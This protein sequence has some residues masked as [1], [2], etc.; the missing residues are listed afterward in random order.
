MKNRLMFFNIK[1]IYI[2]EKKI[3]L[4]QKGPLDS[5]RQRKGVHCHIFFYKRRNSLW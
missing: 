3:L 1:T 4:F 5:R 2:Y